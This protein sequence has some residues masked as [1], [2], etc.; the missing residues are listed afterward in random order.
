MTGCAGQAACARESVAVG[1]KR[2]IARVKYGAEDRRH[3]EYVQRIGPPDPSHHV[4]VDIRPS[5]LA[6]V[7]EQ[8][9]EILQQMLRLGAQ[10]SLYP[11]ALEGLDRKASLRERSAPKRDPAAA[12]ATRV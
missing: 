11:L 1:G 4:P 6:S 12:E 3:G 2:S 7:G 9:P 8:K 5:D 10:T